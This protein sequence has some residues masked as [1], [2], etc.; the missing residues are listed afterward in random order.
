MGNILQQ[1]VETKREEV[2]AALARRPLAEVMRAAR[3]ASPARGFYGAIAAP[4]ARG[5]HVIAEIKRRSPS[6]GLIREDFEPARLAR[7]YLEN[8]AS[9]LSVLTDEK[10]FDGRL[11]YVQQVKAAVPLPVLRKDFMVDEYQLYEARAAGADAILLIGEVLE[12]P[13]L[14]A[15]LDLAFEL[16]MTSLIEVH[17]AST[18]DRL[19]AVV[20]FPND[21]RS[22]LGINNR[23][24]KLQKTDLASTEQLADKAGRGTLLVA[25]SGVKTRDDV[26]R[27][28]AAG[29]SAILIG[30][31]LM[32]SPDIGL[33]M[34][35]LFG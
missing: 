2:A 11:E 16:G 13:R 7:I 8:G 27:M 6:A 17:E 23:N 25:E 1:I 22:L 31:T 19:L 4:S 20:P 30:E 5:I 12:P 21:R 26:Q 18:L 32:R 9:A 10:Y 33:K 28:Q 29:A 14:K 3:L 15:M 35:E 24:L 34:R